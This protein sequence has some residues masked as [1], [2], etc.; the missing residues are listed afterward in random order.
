[1]IRAII[2]DDEELGRRTLRNLLTEYCPSIEVIEESASAASARAAVLK[3]APDV[4]FL[5]IEMPGETGFDLLD[6]IH[7]DHRTF[8]VIFVTAH[9]HYALRAIKASA[10]DYLL[11]PIDIDEL[12]IAVAKLRPPSVEPSETR[13]P[14]ADHVQAVLDNVRAGSYGVTRIALPTALGLRL[15]NPTDIVRCEGDNNYST[16]FLV[17]GDKIIVSRTVREFEDILTQSDFVRIHKSH[18]I[19]L[20]HV[21]QYL[22]ETQRDS[23]GYVVMANGTRLEVSRRKKEELLRRIHFT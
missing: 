15:V 18:L 14:Y 1:M 13:E 17:S 21:R 5:D 4:V 19:N 7:P 3:H 2:V 8:A 6:S 9:D 10:M 16:F 12:R 23:G 22:R 11:K 20:R